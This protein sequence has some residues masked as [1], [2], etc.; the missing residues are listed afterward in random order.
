MFTTSGGGSLLG[1]NRVV[2]KKAVLGLTVTP[3]I[4]PDERLIL[5]VFI[6]QDTF[7]DTV[8]D[9][10]NTK[11]INTQVLLNNGETVIIGGIYQKEQRDRTYKVPFLGDLP[12]LGRLFRKSE[13]YDARSE[14]L[15]FLTPKILETPPPATPPA[16]PMPSM[17]RAAL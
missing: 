7:S 6:T 15:I 2:T 13:H 16:K 14:L 17:S 9:T 3:H 4:T 10:L 5:D 11:Q 1:E 12:V 8:A